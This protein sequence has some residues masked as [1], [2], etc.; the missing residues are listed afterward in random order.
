MAPGGGWPAALPVPPSVLDCM[1]NCGA[2]PCCCPLIAP[3]GGD[4]AWLVP[5]GSAR[6]YGDCCDQQV[7]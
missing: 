4:S 7:V 3:E 5:A 1:P 2:P 6:L